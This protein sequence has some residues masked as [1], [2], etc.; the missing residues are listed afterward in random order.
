[1]NDK[2][3]LCPCCGYYTLATGPRRFGICPACYW[4]DDN[5]QAEAPEYEGGA[6][7][8]SLKQAR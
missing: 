3:N 6:N 2:K 4:E 8:I 5:L 7:D 1:M